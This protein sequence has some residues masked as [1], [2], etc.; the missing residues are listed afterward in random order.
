MGWCVYTRTRGGEFVK[1]EDSGQCN[2]LSEWLP[3]I[4]L[5]FPAMLPFP[6]CRVICMFFIHRKLMLNCF[7]HP[8]HLQFN[9]KFWLFCCLASWH[10]EGRKSGRQ[11]IRI[12]LYLLL[13]VRGLLRKLAL[14]FV[15]LSTFRDLVESWSE[16]QNDFALSCWDHQKLF[17]YFEPDRHN[18]KQCPCRIAF[19]FKMYGIS[20]CCIQLRCV[21]VKW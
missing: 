15:P 2:Y 19:S 12:Y 3:I 5:S 4:S 7:F 20:L 6:L 10:R 1:D 13:S 11:T 9:N 18:G 17:C 16:K 8:P 21:F 14:S